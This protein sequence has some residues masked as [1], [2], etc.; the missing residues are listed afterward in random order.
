[1]FKKLVDESKKCG[2]MIL[3]RWHS[4]Q[5]LRK[6]SHKDGHPALNRNIRVGALPTTSTNLRDTSINSDALGF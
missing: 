2:K 1:M 6:W 3:V 5:D 4:K